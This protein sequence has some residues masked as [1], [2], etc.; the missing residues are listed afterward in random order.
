MY[1]K[2]MYALGATGS[3]IREIFEYGRKR[4]AEIGEENV[5]DFSLGNPSVPAPAEIGNCI[6]NLVDTADT[7]ALHGYTTARGDTS[8]RKSIADNLNRRFSASFSADDLYLTMGAAASL[9]SVFRGLCEKEDEFIVISPYFPEYRVFVESAG[10]KLVEVPADKAG[11]FAPDISAI[12][13]AINPHTKAV[14]IN[15]PNNP[16]GRVYTEK[17]I[18]ELSN[19]LEKRSEGRDPIFL[20]SDEPYRE[21][22]YGGIGYPFVTKYYKNSIVCYSYSKSLS[23]AGERIGYVLFSPDLDCHDEIYKAVAGA[24]RSLG[25]VCAPSLFQHVIEKCADCSCD[26][27]AYEQNRETLCKILDELGF[28]YVSPD[29]AFY[30]FLK[31]PDPDEN[32]FC[33]IAK[34]FELLLVPSE[35]FGVRGYVR[36]SYCVDR[37]MIERSAAAFARLADR[38]GL[39][40]KA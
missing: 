39:R 20:I 6:K 26:I 13:K 29:G 28:E 18:A 21:L 4:K 12:D 35:S 24:A 2:E 22:I 38:C 10:G 40:K 32:R 36:I 34:N 33:E 25:Y 27:S 3:V 17:E 9:M 19:L 23:L 5:F 1:N 11:N 31:S 7:L 30:L 15:S 16:T 37:L 14:I 8:A